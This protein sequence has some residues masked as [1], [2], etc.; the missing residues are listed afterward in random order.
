MTKRRSDIAPLPLWSYLDILHPAASMIWLNL[1]PTRKCPSSQLTWYRYLSSFH[2]YEWRKVWITKPSPQNVQN[3]KHNDSAKTMTDNFLW[4]YSFANVTPS[5]CAN[6]VQLPTPTHSHLSEMRRRPRRS[7]MSRCPRLERF[8]N[9]L[10][11]YCRF[12]IA[13]G[14]QS[15]HTVHQSFTSLLCSFDSKDT[16]KGLFGQHLYN[17]FRASVP[18]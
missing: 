17:N 4:L 18:G 3:G 1:R 5:T 11:P 14:K 8:Q 16:Q 6:D 12:P 10:A 13:P 2:R 7:N 9:D 15:G